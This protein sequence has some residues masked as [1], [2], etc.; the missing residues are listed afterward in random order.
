MKE[1]IFTIFLLFSFSAFGQSSRSELANS[2][3]YVRATYFNQINEFIGLQTRTD[4]S[5]TIINNT[6]YKKFKAED[7]TDY[8]NKRIGNIFYEAFADGLYTLLDSKFKVVHKLN[9][10]TEKEQQAIIFGNSI[11]TSFEPIDTRNSFPRDS[12]VLTEKTPRKYYQSDNSEI[13]LI[14]FPDLKTLAVSSNGQF[15][16]KHLLGDNYNDITNGLNNNYKASTK[17]DIQK[18]DEIQ[19]FY[20]RKWYNDTTNVT[21]YEDKQFKNIKYIGDTSVNRIKAMKFEIEGYNYLSGSADNA[22]EFLVPLTDS[23]YKVGYHFV[24]FKNFQTELKLIDNNG[25]K[26]FF[27]Q[28]VTFDT[29]GTSIYPKI[30]QVKSNDPYRYFILPFFPMPFI[31]FGNVQ[32]IIT[33]TRIN[34]VTKGLKRERSYITKKNNIRSIVSKSKSKVE[35]IIYFVDKADV[36][37]SIMDFDTNKTFGQL[38]S[39]AKQ[40]LNSIIVPADNLEQGKEYR[41]EINYKGYKS[42]GSFS[43]SV[44]AKF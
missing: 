18:G 14:I 21:V 43:N 16:T 17:F 31:E 24:P 11:Q 32:G 2:K 4:L 26:E 29:I 8:A 10:Q 44:K 13:Y 38:K 25:N 40:G 20:R 36:E 12:L 7:F 34:G 6:K 33:Y 30:V 27:L 39:P 23:G 9:Y 15:Y 1:L 28:G 35:V 41:V 37:I 42:S 19:L 3:L 5:D 22:E